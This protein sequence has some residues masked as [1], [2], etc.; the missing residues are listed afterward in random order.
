MGSPDRPGDRELWRL[1]GDGDSAAFGELFDR[2]ATAVYNHLF[3]RTGSWSE[4][5]DLTSAVFLQAWHRRTRVVIDRESA[6]PWLLGVT[7]W[8][9][10]S[11]PSAGWPSCAGP[12]P[13][14]PATSA[15]SSSCA[16]GR[17]STRR[18]PPWPSA[19]S[20]AV[21]ATAGVGPV[22]VTVPRSPSSGHV[23]RAGSDVGS[24]TV[25]GG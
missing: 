11:T 13:N 17:V 9:R 25:T 20:Y 14:S 12:W 19:C 8:P 10:P 23:I 7:R 24:V 5:E 3:R 6:L 1:A 2:H 4:A 16:P 21:T 15:R 18:A 22:T